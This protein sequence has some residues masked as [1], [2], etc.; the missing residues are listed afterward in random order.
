MPKWC[1]VE[2]VEL[3]IAH[4]M[5]KPCLY[6]D[7]CGQGAVMSLCGGGKRCGMCVAIGIG[8]VMCK[9]ERVLM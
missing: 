4:S 7:R 2:L 5:G 9:K 8:H 3:C 6:P 1:E